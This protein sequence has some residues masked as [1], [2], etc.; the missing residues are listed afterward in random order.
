MTLN[1]LM[2]CKRCH[3]HEPLWAHDLGNFCIE[4]AHLADQIKADECK[5]LA[6]LAYEPHEFAQGDAVWDLISGDRGYFF[7]EG[8]HCYHV[9]VDGEVKQYPKINIYLSN[10]E[11]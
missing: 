1:E 8:L 10:V 2:K 7:T 11:D 3:R 9:L 5:I 6:F 4:C